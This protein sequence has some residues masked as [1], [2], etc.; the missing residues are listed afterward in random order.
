LYKANFSLLFGCESRLFRQERLDFYRVKSRLAE[1][2]GIH[3]Q[4]AENN[5]LAVFPFLETI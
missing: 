4:K 3:N 1:K 5:F 2:N